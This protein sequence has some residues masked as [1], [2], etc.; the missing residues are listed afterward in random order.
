[1]NQPI[2]ADRRRGRRVPYRARV[3]TSNGMAA[4]RTTNL[5][6]GGMCLQR[7]GEAPLR[8]G[9]AIHLLVDLPI[10]PVSVH[11]RVVSA[12]DGVFYQSVAVVF[13]AMPAEHRARLADFVHNRRG[14]LPR[15]AILARI[16]LRR[17]RLAA[18]LAQVG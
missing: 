15:G 2:Y 5:S 1:M 12:I 17:M 4:G 14:F 6:L 9:Q 10:G 8:I 18:P 7:S 13:V 3:R 16:P 11:G